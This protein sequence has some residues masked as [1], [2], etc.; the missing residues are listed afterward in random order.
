MEV[1]GVIII[2]KDNKLTQKLNLSFLPFYISKDP[3]IDLINTHLKIIHEKV[4]LTEI[5]SFRVSDNGILSELTATVQKLINFSYFILTKGTEINDKTMVGSEIYFRKAFEYIK[6]YTEINSDFNLDIINDLS[7]FDNFTILNKKLV[8]IKVILVKNIEQIL[9]RGE[10]LD[11]LIEKSK[12]LSNKA[13]I[14]YKET[15][16]VN[17]CCIIM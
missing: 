7:K 14:F 16:K 4:K 9:E 11:V 12:D 13:K 1:I 17:K 3:I 15:K 6:K 10:K 8:D 2:D 5:Q